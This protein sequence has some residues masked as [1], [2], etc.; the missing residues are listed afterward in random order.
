[1]KK[2]KL[3]ILLATS[4][5][6]SIYIAPTPLPILQTGSL[7]FYKIE[8]INECF[9]IKTHH[10]IPPHS[11]VFFTDTEWNGNRF[12]LGEH[13]LIWNSGEHHILAGSMIYFTHINSTPI[14]S[15]GDAKGLMRIV[16]HKDAI[17]VYQGS[18]RMP[19]HFITGFAYNISDFGTLQN[20]GL[21]VDSTATVLNN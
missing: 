9:V 8:A 7:S 21:L 14:T 12:T 2:T 15:I 1:M 17:F 11:Q 18:E 19:T 16:P 4:L 13:T 20:T 3:S 5:L 6:L 10:T